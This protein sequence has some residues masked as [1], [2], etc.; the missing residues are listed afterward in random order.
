M[1]NVS[2]YSTGSDS[3]HAGQARNKRTEIRS[4]KE[5][6]NCRAMPLSEERVNTIDVMQSRAPYNPK[7][8]YPENPIDHLVEKTNAL[9]G[10]VTDIL[11]V[12]SAFLTEEVQLKEVIKHCF[13]L[14]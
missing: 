10:Q 4:F 9:E 3:K 2:N 8:L 13:P 11:Q 5:V 1:R 6:I 12:V 14:A 7:F